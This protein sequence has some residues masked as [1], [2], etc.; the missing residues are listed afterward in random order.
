[1]TDVHGL[2]M[3][4]AHGF[5]LLGWALTRSG[6]AAEGLSHMLETQQALSRMGSLIHATMALGFHAKALLVAGQFAEG[7]A[8]VERTVS[9]ATQGGE[10]SYLAW[11]YRIRAEALL[12][13]HGN[14]DPQIEASLKQA[15]DIAR[16]QG[17]KGWEIGA[18]TDLARLWAEQRRRVEARELLAPLYGWF[19]E[20]F[21]TADLKAA[22]ALLDELS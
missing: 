2:P 1:L 6:K 9:I 4:R 13:V 11:L 20:G 18:A 12:H 3:P 10:H 21:A 14:A 8:E 19:T 22:K 15:L 17:A 7:L 5:N 16:G